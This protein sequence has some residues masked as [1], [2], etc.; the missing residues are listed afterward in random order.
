MARVY[1]QTDARGLV[2]ES[3]V[4][5]GQLPAPWRRLDDDEVM[6]MDRLDR[7][8]EI[9]GRL[10]RRRHIALV[11]ST[12]QFRADGDDALSINVRDDEHA[13]APD[14]PVRVTINGIEHS[15]TKADP[16]LLTT[17]TPGSFLVHLDDP[18]F[19]SYNNPVSAYAVEAD[20]A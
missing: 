10:Q 13:L 5:S 7:V 20:S 18:G 12:S 9:D 19:F 8:V 2:T 4:T 3:R 16:I 14:E 1:V 15:V 6:L 11:L 17:T